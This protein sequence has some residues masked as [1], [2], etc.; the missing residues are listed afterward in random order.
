M[1]FAV[2]SV[3]WWPTCQTVILCCRCKKRSSRCTGIILVCGNESVNL[4]LC[5]CVCQMLGDRGGHHD[6]L[7]STVSWRS[8]IRGL[9]QQ[10]VKITL[11]S[12]LTKHV[13]CVFCLLWRFCVC[14]LLSKR[15]CGTGKGVTA[16]LLVRQGIDM[17][18][19]PR[20][21]FWDVVK[22]PNHRQ[23]LPPAT[24]TNTQP[25]VGL[26][27][28][29]PVPGCWRQPRR[30]QKSEGIRRDRRSEE[31]KKTTATDTTTKEHFRYSQKK[32][33]AISLLV[34]YCFVA[35]TAEF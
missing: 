2:D 7:Y 1:A 32:C 15:V 28:C 25:Y 5:V 20:Q 3:N 12:S 13:L 33:G 8:N 16:G 29:H 22:H 11:L 9:L 17:A 6:A 19:R 27:G 30:Y 34:F 24:T 23:S 14:T 26:S 21:L 18:Q 10:G 35:T 31:S 4:Y